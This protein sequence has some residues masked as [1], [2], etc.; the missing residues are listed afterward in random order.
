MKRLNGIYI[1]VKNEKEYQAIKECLQDLDFAEYSATDAITDLV[2]IRMHSNA[3]SKAEKH[4]TITPGK[5]IYSYIEFILL[6]NEIVSFEPDKILEKTYL[7]NFYEFVKNKINDTFSIKI[8]ATT[9][10]IALGKFMLN[11][12]I[13]SADDRYIKLLNIKEI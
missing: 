11:K 3:F 2:Y 12:F 8:K 1:N 10:E 5:K 4:W 6:Y 13:T 9:K 7:I